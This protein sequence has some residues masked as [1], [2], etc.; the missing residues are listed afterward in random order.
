[1]RR[2]PDMAYEVAP[3]AVK[4][5]L[6]AGADLTGK[7]YYAMYVDTSGNAQVITA[8]NTVAQA[9]IGILQNAPKFSSG[10][11]A[12]EAEIAMVG[13]VKAIAGGTV[14]IGDF[15]GAD[16]N[17]KI[18]KYTPGTD[19]TKFIIGRCLVGGAANEILTIAINTTAVHRGA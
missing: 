12:E 1:M 10:A 15:V 7:Q 19:T 3:Y 18:V 13:V 17:G 4:V 11:Y 16:T 14:A 9:A 6:P 5:T 2:V 8:D